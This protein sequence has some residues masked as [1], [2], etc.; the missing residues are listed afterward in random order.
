MRRGDA[1]PDVLGEV[2]H[3]INIGDGGEQAEVDHSAAVRRRVRGAR[4]VVLDVCGV[5]NDR[6]ADTG[7]LVEQAPLVRRA[8]QVD[9]VGVAIGAELLTPKLAPVRPNVE[10][11]TQ[12][13]AGEG[14]LPGQ[15]VG[16]LVRVYDQGWWLLPGRSLAQVVVAKI[17][18]L[19]VDDVEPP[20]AQDPVQDL[21]QRWQRDPQPLEALG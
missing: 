14:E 21:L 7:D 16:D 11:T 10:T 9:P 19:Q 2:G 20:R 6:R 4:L 12:A 5:G 3:A 17:R 15:V 13:S 8:A 18:E 1:G